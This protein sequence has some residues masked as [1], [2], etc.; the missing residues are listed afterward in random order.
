MFNK[1]ENKKGQMQA[2]MLFLV[3]V[4]IGVTAFYVG[5]DSLPQLAAGAGGQP[6]APAQQAGTPLIVEGKIDDTTV[7][8]S[9]WNLFAKGTEPGLGHRILNLNGQENIQ[10]NEDGTT[11][12]SPFQKYKVVIGNVTTG[13]SYYAEYAEGTIPNSGTHSI[14]SG[15]CAIDTSVSFTYKNEDGTANTAQAMSASTTYTLPVKFQ[16]SDNQCYGSP[17][18]KIDNIAC[19]SGNTTV[20]KTLS[21]NGETKVGAPTAYS[22]PGSGNAAGT[23]AWCYTIRKIADNGK[24]EGDLIVTTQSTGPVAANDLNV[25]LYDA[26]FD[27]DAD[28]LAIIGGIYV[29]TDGLN[30]PVGAYEDEANNDIGD[31]TAQKYGIQ[32]S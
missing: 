12:A 24:Y 19:F 21:L 13:G 8:F 32:V 27:Y 5:K 30:H 10:K 15:L 16:V 4:A 26:A 23:S 25:T 7:T 31:T 28:T 29:G 20:Y 6:A 2:F 1:K 9:S 17:N 11:T 18:V 14:S 22:F 3:I